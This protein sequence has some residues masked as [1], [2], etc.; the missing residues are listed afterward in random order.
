MIAAGSRSRVR[1]IVMAVLAAGVVFAPV[2]AQPQVPTPG[3]GPLVIAKQSFF[4]IGGHYDDAHPDRHMVGQMYVEY[5]IPQELKHP[6]PI[7]MV[8]GGTATGLEWKGT[9][10]GREGWEQYFLRR[11]YAVYV[12]DQVAR[13]RSPYETQVYGKTSSQTTQYILERFT[14]TERFHLWPQAG[15][16]TQWP[17]KAEPGDPAYDSYAA[18]NFAGMDNRESQD[19]MNVHALDVLLDKIGPSI[20]FVHSQ[21]GQYAWP[22]AQDRPALVKAIVAVEAAG[23]PVHDLVVKG[24][25]PRFGVTFDA[26]TKQD[27]AEDQ[28]RDGP[29]LKTYGLTSHRLAYT[30][31]ITAQSPLLFERQAKA[32]GHDLARCWRQKEPA[33]KLVAVGDRPIIYI[34]AEAS[35]YAPYS[36]CTVAYLEQAGAHVDFVKL[37]DIGIHGNGHLMMIE[38]NSDEI[39]GVVSD[40]LDKVMAKAESETRAA[41]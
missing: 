6:F 35:F 27:E 22:L 30:P 37:A 26:A 39:A 24:G 14:A 10:D 21:S 1:S 34:A 33:K 12:V 28:F 3:K 7:V 31:S 40:W 36:H 19:A 13:G 15:L 29:Q 5:Q 8:H 17:G 18:S 25:E 4:Y 38:K 2:A 41:R 16:H 11:G 23:P 9:P 20:V 32:D